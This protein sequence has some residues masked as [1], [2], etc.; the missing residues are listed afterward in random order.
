[1]AEALKLNSDFLTRKCQNAFSLPVISP[2]MAAMLIWSLLCSLFLYYNSELRNSQ[3][4]TLSVV[5]GEE[6]RIVREHVN[7]DDAPKVSRAAPTRILG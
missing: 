6:N 2:D 1:M 3:S 5:V 4:G 7:L